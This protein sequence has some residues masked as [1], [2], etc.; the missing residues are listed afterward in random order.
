MFQ[1]NW[2]VIATPNIQNAFICSFADTNWLTIITKITMMMMMMITTKLMMLGDDD[3]D[4][5]DN[6]NNCYDDDN[7]ELIKCT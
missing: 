4:D 3:N 1:F 2:R 5:D 6:D 7:D